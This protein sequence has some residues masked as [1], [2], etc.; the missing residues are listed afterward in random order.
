MYEKE[1]VDVKNPKYKVWLFKDD[2]KLRNAIEEYY[3]SIPK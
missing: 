2:N 3:S 1:T